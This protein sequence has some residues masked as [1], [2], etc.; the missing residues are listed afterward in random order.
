M[1]TIRFCWSQRQCRGGGGLGKHKAQ[2]RG[3]AT[4]PQA[5]LRILQPQ[6]SCTAFGY[7]VDSRDVLVAPQKNKPPTER[8]TCS[9]LWAVSGVV[10][11]S[12]LVVKGTRQALFRAW[13]LRQDTRPR[14][15][16]EVHPCMWPA[17]YHHH[18]LH[19]SQQSQ[20]G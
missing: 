15:D 11:S 2:T 3:P 6:R 12:A 16:N 1:H 7:I 20:P 5:R 4:Y 13:W 17:N 10:F 14:T 8:G 19:T 18:I 9:T